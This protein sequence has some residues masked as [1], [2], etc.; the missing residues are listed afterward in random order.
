MSVIGLKKANC[1]NCYKCLKVCPVKSIRVVNEQAQIIDDDC[2]LCGTCLASCPQ[3]AKT[4][5]SSL[6]QVKEMVAAGEKVAVS[7][8]PSFLGSFSL[9]KPGQMAAALKKLGFC[10]VSETA[11]GAAYVTAQYHDLMVENKMKN[12]ITTCCPSINRLIELYHPEVVGYMAPVV[13][14]MIASARLIKQALGK[15]VKV[16]FVGPCIA[17]IDEAAD[18]RHD[19]D[20][21]A[22]LTFEDIEQWF[23]E[24]GIVPS[25]CEDASFLNANSKILRMYPVTSGILESLKARGDCDHYRMLTVDGI[26]ECID[27][28]SSM[29]KGELDHCFVEVNACKGGCVNGPAKT[30]GEE[31]RFRAALDVENYAREDADAY[32]AVDE[33]IPM[34]KRFFDRS[35]HEK[36]PDED[37]IR[38]ILTKIGKES[39]EQEL[40]CGACGY[41]SCREKAIAVYLNKAELTMCVP[42]MKER[43]ESLSNYV[44]SETPNITI[45]VDDEMNI[46]E[47]NKA[48]EECFKISR[49]E[50]LEKGLFELIDSSDFQFVLETKQ[51]ITNKK[52]H[53]K[54][55][56]I[57]TEQSIIYID[58]QNIV[59][60]IFKDIT[61]EER[62]QENL[63]DLR[64]ETMEMAQKVID[65]QMVAAQ[66]IASLLGET[67]AETKV[68]LTK[69]KNMIV[70]DGDE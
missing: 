5:T 1:K 69:L 51:P 32:P 61:K 22:V 44:L 20:V 37:T 66:Q 23:R 38:S 8:A 42:Y 25:Q 67:T 57:T 9:E 30:R 49:R 3:N 31:T 21:D 24:E 29:A 26:Q 58:K 45:M 50:A 7:L 2:L 12:I 33:E 15:G 54:E 56:G 19:T 10:A 6:D 52:V 47:F 68:T 36:L 39:P 4:L 62:E 11:Q 59:M 48:A 65:K 53:Y 41:N 27:L 35:R 63:Y 34:G 46:I 17:K 43:A 14:P 55:Y 18:I 64:V 60:G 13:S 16:V 40:N 70:F 28:F